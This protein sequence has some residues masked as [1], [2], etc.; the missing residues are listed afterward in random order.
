MANCYVRTDRE[1]GQEVK[2]PTAQ[3]MELDPPKSRNNE[4]MQLLLK[5]LSGSQQGTKISLRDGQ[6]VQ[7]G[8]TE[9]AEVSFPDDVQMSSIHCAVECR[10]DSCK[11][12]D[13]KS[14][15]GTYI[16][17]E[18][19]SESLLSDG[20]E[21]RAGTTLFAVQIEGPVTTSSA[22]AVF[23][24]AAGLLKTIP[25]LDSVALRAQAPTENPVA[26][27]PI[28][29]S[30]ETSVRSPA[31]SQPR[32]PATQLVLESVGG[33][34]EG[35]KIFLR[36]GQTATIGR[37]D[38]ADFAIPGDLQLSSLHFAIDWL[39]GSFRL[40]DLGSTNGTKVNDHQVAETI[41]EDG[42]RITAGRTQFVVHIESE[43]ASKNAGRQTVV[44]SIP[45]IMDDADAEVRRI[46]LGSAAWAKQGWVLDYCR[47]LCDHP[48]AE[49]IDAIYLLGVLGR[50]VDLPSILAIGS[51]SELGP[52]R[53]RVLGAFGHAG[54]MELLLQAIAG[55]EANDAV[56][57]GE[58]FERI[59]GTSL[60][61]NSQAAA[62]SEQPVAVEGGAPPE[63]LLLPGAE[64]ARAD[65]EK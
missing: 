39:D 26:V 14:T 32:G 53:F 47:R 51:N 46:A 13:L 62:S 34:S 21:I 20:D 57:A 11:I 37:T 22:P 55:A 12:R 1:R 9:W 43:A 27:D 3:E 25:D 60:A 6:V 5:V 40:R 16:N 63:E 4:I 61:W 41:L 64:Q 17:G 30:S 58:A 15:N 36:A 31:V 10:E 18:K 29:Q 48:K 33:S 23:E 56:I 59:T 49:Y 45:S 24:G 35:Q 19:I 28:P 42:D 50:P 38:R 2:L 7:I 52:D 65:W 44:T 8:R 54:I